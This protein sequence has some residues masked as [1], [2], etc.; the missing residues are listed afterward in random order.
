[1]VKPSVPGRRHCVM[2]YSD[3]SKQ[4]YQTTSA[5]SAALPG[6]FGRPSLDEVGHALWK[7]VGLHQRAEPAVHQWCTT[8]TIILTGSCQN[9]GRSAKAEPSED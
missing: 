3:P 4:V 6:E 1:M 9:D 7:V 2:S 8:C 5:Q